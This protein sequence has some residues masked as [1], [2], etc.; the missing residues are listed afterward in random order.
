MSQDS[1][2]RLLVAGISTAIVLAAP[3][4]AKLGLPAPSPESALSVAGLIV[5]V[6]LAQS[7]GA[8]VA[9]H[10]ASS[11]MLAAALDAGHTLEAAVKAVQAVQ[12]ASDGKSAGAQA[13]ASPAAP[14]APSNS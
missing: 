6:F 2:K 5:S 13:A 11:K 7:G 14:S 1:L 10:L 4:L 8:K 12:A 9:Q 3:L